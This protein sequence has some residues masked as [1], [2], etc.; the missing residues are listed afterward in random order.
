MPVMMTSS[1][2]CCLAREGPLAPL[3]DFPIFWPGDLRGFMNWIVALQVQ[4]PLSA[5]N[6]PQV[7]DSQSRQAQVEDWRRLEIQIVYRAHGR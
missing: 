2:E 3:F 6:W 5:L 4:P 1:G 7:F